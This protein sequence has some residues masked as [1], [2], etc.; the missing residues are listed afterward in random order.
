M[1]PSVVDCLRHDLALIQ[2]DFLLVTGDIVSAQT[3]DAAFAA[4]DLMDSLQIPYRPMGGNH[5]FISP[6]SRKWFLEAFGDLLPGG[7]TAYSFTHKNLFF[8]ALDAWW[9]WSD[10]SLCASSESAADFGGMGD[11]EDADWAIPP[12]QVAWLE[13]Q[14]RAHQD[15]P[16]VVASHYPLIDIPLRLRRPGMQDAGHLSNGSLLLEVLHDYP[17][18]KAV[19]SGHVHLNFIERNTQLTHVSTGALPEFPTEFREIRVYD[20]RMEVQTHGLSDTSFAERSLIPG[21]EWTRGEACDRS[22]VISF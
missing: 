12:H 14:L 9:K 10:G 21:K 11:T 16:T 1:M 4:R 13:E 15:M 20:D 5:D 3:R 7:S 6:D 18:V 19:F 17:Q 22:A 8:C 2:P